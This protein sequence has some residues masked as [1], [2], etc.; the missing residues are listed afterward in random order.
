MFMNPCTSAELARQRQQEML[1]QAGRQRLARRL[2]ATS[3]AAP[4]RQR[5]RD[6]LR[7]AVRLRP[8]PGT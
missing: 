1:T 4:S 7:A 8:V 6:A 5:L 3:G 2:R